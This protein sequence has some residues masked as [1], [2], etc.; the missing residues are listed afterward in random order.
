MKDD[1]EHTVGV[2]ERQ[3]QNG[4]GYTDEERGKLKEA[5]D[6]LRKK[7]TRGGP[8]PSGAPVNDTVTR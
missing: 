6:I 2:L 7:L 3:S 8:A 4:G 5:A 1:R